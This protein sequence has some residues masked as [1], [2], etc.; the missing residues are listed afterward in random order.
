MENQRL[1]TILTVLFSIGTGACIG[2]ALTSNPAIGALGLAGLVYNTYK[3]W[4]LM[5]DVQ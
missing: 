3:N 5:Q 2:V 4:K 1:D